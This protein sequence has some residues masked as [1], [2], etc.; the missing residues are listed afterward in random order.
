MSKT[1][2]IQETLEDSFSAFY[3]IG[4][5]KIME[6]LQR[7]DTVADKNVIDWKKKI[8]KLLNAFKCLF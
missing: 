1:I 4:Q 7:I 6:E 8:S 3:T 5:K 2:V